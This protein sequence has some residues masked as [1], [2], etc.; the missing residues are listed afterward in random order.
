MKGSIQS[1]AGAIPSRI[2]LIQTVF[3]SIVSYPSTSSSE[4]DVNS[5][6]ACLLFLP[7]LSSFEK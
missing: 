1:L 2:H 5:D 6:V 3:E 4:V 7:L